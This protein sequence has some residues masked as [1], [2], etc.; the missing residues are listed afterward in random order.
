MECINVLGSEHTYRLE[1]DPQLVDQ[2]DFEEVD[3][4]IMIV[5]EWNASFPYSFKKLIDDS[6]HPSKLK[7]KRVLLI[8]TSNTTF[9][10]VMGITHLKQILEWI[11]ADVS[12][13]LVCVPHIDDKFED[14]NIVI[15]SRLNQTILEFCS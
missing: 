3:R 2:G 15:D 5:P 4:I 12:P 7:G 9:G 10:N 14:N 13:K 8:G 1:C 11:G 6:G